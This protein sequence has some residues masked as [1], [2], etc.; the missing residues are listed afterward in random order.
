MKLRIVRKGSW[1]LAC[2]PSE[3]RM[4]GVN[5]VK[6]VYV[7]QLQ[8]YGENEEGVVGWHPVEVVVEDPPPHPYKHSR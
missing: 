1:E 3:V 4:G 6:L 7:D 2:S 8:Y 5:P